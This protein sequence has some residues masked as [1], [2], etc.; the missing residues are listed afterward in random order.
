MKKRVITAVILA[1]VLIPLLFVGEVWFY[2]AV[3]LLALVAAGELFFLMHRNDKPRVVFFT[4]WILSSY[5]LYW[6]LLS[7]YLGALEGLW[8][9]LLLFAFTAMLTMGA[10]FEKTITVSAVAQ[11]LFA[12]VFVAVAF[13]AI[14][15]VRSHGVLVLVYVLMVAML[16][17]MFAYFVGITVGKHKLAPMV[18]PKKTVEGA[19]GGTLIGVAIAGVFAG[20]FAVF[21]TATTFGLLS[22]LIVGGVFIAAMAQIGDLV[23]SNWK[24][25]HGVKDFSNLFPGR[26]GV[27]DRFDSSVFAAMALTIVMMLLE[28][29]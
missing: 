18:S 3:S 5:V 25:E 13:S 7:V 10:L 21:D 19:V 27:L 28:V 4:V 29:F 6:V 9:V 1:V 15:M 11:A 20:V 12:I 8:I 14:S 17:D 2:A 16:T 24:R 26:G 23:A 22:L